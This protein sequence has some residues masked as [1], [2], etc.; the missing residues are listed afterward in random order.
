M[1]DEHQLGIDGLEI[2]SCARFVIDIVEVRRIGEVAVGGD[3]PLQFAGVGQVLQPAQLAAAKRVTVAF[4]GVARKVDE[5]VGASASRNGIVVVAGQNDRAGFSHERQCVLRQGPV[6]DDIP[7]AD[8]LI[9]V[10]LGG[11]RKHVPQ[12]R[13]VGMNVGDDRVAHKN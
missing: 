1:A 5:I 13:F 2:G 7:E 6:A 11:V 12:G 9:N 10:Q 4:D 8:N 3:G